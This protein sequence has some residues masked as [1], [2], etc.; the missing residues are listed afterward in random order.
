VCDKGKIMLVIAGFVLLAA[1]LALW[2]LVWLTAQAL[3]ACNDDFI[4]Y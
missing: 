3:P 2:R 1:A 4:F